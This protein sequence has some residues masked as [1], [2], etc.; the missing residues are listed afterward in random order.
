MTRLF[1]D[2]TSLVMY[3]NDLN[4]L[5]NHVSLTFQKLSRWCMENKLTISM[6]KTN[7]LFSHTPNKPLVRN[8]REIATENMVIT[9][10]DAIKYLGITIDEKLTWNAHVEYVCNS[11][12]N[13]FSSLNNCV[14]KWPQ[15]QFDNLI[16]HL[17]TLK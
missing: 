9:R 14:T 2:D 3:D 1:A 10:V 13:I 12:K 7:F 8:V 17:Y 6:E 16:M 11:L 15:I 4:I 5:V